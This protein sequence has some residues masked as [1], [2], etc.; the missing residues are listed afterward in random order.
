MAYQRAFWK[1]QIM[2]TN[3]REDGM[4]PNPEAPPMHNGPGEFDMSM[5]T[6]ANK[7]NLGTSQPR[8]KGNKNRDELP[9]KHA[10][11][12]PR[13]RARHQVLMAHALRNG[14]DGTTMGTAVGGGAAG[15]GAGGG[16]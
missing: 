3:G 16:S 15:G 11:V 4:R 2:R 6:G 10:H 13:S 12:Q 14:P 7:P 9:L 8:V 5:E 1:G